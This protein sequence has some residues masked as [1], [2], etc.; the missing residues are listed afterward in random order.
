MLPNRLAVVL[1]GLL[2]GRVLTMAS[3]G[4]SAVFFGGAVRNRSTFRQSDAIDVKHALILMT[5]VGCRPREPRQNLPLATDD[6]Q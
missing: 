4:P 1:V 5:A 6:N 2:P 3:D